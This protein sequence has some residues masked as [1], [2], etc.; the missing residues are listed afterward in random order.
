MRR[1]SLS[2]R[3]YRRLLLLLALTG[4]AM[5]AI[6]YSVANREVG[7]AADAQ[8]V[9]ASRMLYMMMQ[10]DIASALLTTHG[11]EFAGDG[12]HLLTAEE[13]K[14]FRASYDWYMFVI[15]WDGEPIA[16]SGWAAP[17]NLVPRKKGLHDFTAG[18]DQWRSYGLH[19]RDP[20]LLIVV[21]ERDA[22]REFAIL[23]VLR[24]L[25]LPM[26]L[27]I[28][29]GMAVLWW[30][31]RK[32]LSEVDRLAL[33][34]NARS[35]SDLSPLVPTEWSKDLE[36]LIVALNKLFVRLGQ[37]YELEQD[38]T[39]DVAHELRTPLAAMRAQSELVRKMAPPPLMEDVGRLIA[40]VDRANALIDGM[41]T[42]ARLNATSVS[43]RSVDIHALVGEVVAD[44]L[45]QLPADAMEFNV[46][47]DH[48]VRW[49]CDPT[50][51]QI[52]LS[53]VIENATRHARAGARVDIAITRSTDRLVITIGDRGPGVR[54]ADRERLF[55]RFERGVSTAFGSGLGLSIAMKAIVL[56]G[57]SIRL[58]DR[59]GAGLLVILTLPGSLE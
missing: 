36:P 32:G 58:E 26:F 15:F 30:T 38:F 45:G 4:F 10:D 29:A 31:L 16:Q 50:P 6:L 51:L 46:T 39:D 55:R 9:N 12:D 13:R 11:H 41:L 34:L 33:T 3:L 47:P 20:R 44:A 53:A 23:P 57:G 18:H 21:A 37:A 56:S 2:M 5:G 25:A 19:G 49:R 22:M 40:I 59:D 52:A 14:A 35:L 43:V 48:V 28:A 7:R 54:P 1:S 24:Q 27:L 42:L 8:L 17:I